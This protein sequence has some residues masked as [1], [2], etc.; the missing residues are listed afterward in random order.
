MPTPTPSPSSLALATMQSF[1]TRGKQSSAKWIERQQK[2]EYVQK[3]RELGLPSRSY[4]KLQ[5][6]NER[7][8]PT[9]SKITKK[10][11]KEGNNNKR[12]MKRLIQPGMLVLDLG[13]APGGWSLYA[14]EHLKPERG[15]AVVALDLLPL[16]KSLSSTNDAQSDT[17]ARIRANLDDNFQFI[18]GDFTNRHVQ[19]QIM[20]AIQDL[21]ETDGFTTIR[22]PDIVMSDM[23]AN[24]TGDTR[25][26]ALRTLS[27][28]EESLGFAAGYDCFDSS[29][30]PR[31]GSDGMLSP[32]GSFI[33]K[34]FTCGQEDER[35]LME[36]TKR[37]FRK[38][39]TIK[40]KASRKESAEMYL[41][42]LDL[43][44]N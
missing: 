40:P 43:K 26:D 28:C 3:A 27:L 14:S 1:S 7:H 8:A 32:G 5:E 12:T 42:A 37:A 23:A 39:H 44:G 21:S 9:L 18:Q 15:G 17:F 24:F 35:D 4:F 16:D 10:G 13:A 2:D 25:T 20:N 34:Y 29:Y 41:L 6:I 22:K 30:S 11:K 19:M 38:V 33:C 31:D 36:A